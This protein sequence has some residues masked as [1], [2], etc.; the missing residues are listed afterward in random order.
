MEDL[1]SEY[2]L[3]MTEV[4]PPV[5]PATCKAPAAKPGAAARGGAEGKPPTPSVSPGRDDSGSIKGTAAAATAAATIATPAATATTVGTFPCL[6]ENLSG[7]WRCLANSP[8]CKGGKRGP[9]R[10]T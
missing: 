3:N 2:K 6:W 5:P 4:W 8:H 10:G 7:T 9:T 1:N